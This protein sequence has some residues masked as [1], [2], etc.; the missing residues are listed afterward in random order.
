MIRIIGAVLILV[1]C[2]GCASLATV[3]QRAIGVA[4]TMEG[5]Y[6][7]LKADVQLW[8]DKWEAATNIVATMC[9]AGQISDSRCLKLAVVDDVA[10][11]AWILAQ[12]VDAEAADLGVAKN[13]ILDAMV[14][15]EAAMAEVETVP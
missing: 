8:A 13:K 15:I 2:V 9:A 6:S 12:R 10:D 11:R 3:H 4:E 7:V 5:A 1:M 14:Q